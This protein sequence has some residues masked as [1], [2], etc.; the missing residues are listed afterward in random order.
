MT[1]VFPYSQGLGGMALLGG[2]WGVWQLITG[3]LIARW[4]SKR[5]A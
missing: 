4:W 1:L 2:W 5:T 3:G